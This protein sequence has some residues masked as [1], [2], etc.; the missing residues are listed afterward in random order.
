MNSQWH[1]EWRKKNGFESPLGCEIAGT[2][3]LTKY[4]D[5]R[6]RKEAHLLNCWVHFVFY[7]RSVQATFKWHGEEK[8]LCT[9]LSEVRDERALKEEITCEV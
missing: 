4:L 9:L 3:F 1:R 8:K 2:A 7:K 5:T 6:G